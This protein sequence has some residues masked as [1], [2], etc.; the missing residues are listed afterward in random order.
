[1]ASTRFSQGLYEDVH[2]PG[3]LVLLPGARHLPD[4][5]AD[6]VHALVRGALAL[7]LGVPQ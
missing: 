1:M 2:A 5:A 4:G 3:W 7:A 6:E